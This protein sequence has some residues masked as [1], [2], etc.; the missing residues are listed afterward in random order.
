LTNGWINYSHN[1][2]LVKLFSL[3]LN[4]SQIGHE[5]ANKILQ[6]DIERLKKI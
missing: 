6:K 2:T 4:S 5:A 1:L 3:A